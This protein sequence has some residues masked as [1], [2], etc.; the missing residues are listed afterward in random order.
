MESSSV[1]QVDPE[2]LI[3]L[4]DVSEVRLK[5]SLE[6]APAQRPHGVLGVWSPILSAVGNAFKL[7]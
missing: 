2:I 1:A 7:Q 6:T 4:I 5:L 3:N